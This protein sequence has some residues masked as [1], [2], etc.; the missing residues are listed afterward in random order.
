MSC[1]VL[2][3]RPFAACSIEAGYA[4][5]VYASGRTHHPSA[6]QRTDAGKQYNGGQVKPVTRRAVRYFDKNHIE[7]NRLISVK[8]EPAK[9]LE[10]RHAREWFIDNGKPVIDGQKKSSRFYAI[11]GTA[12][13]RQFKEQAAVHNSVSIVKVRTADPHTQ[14]IFTFFVSRRC[15]EMVNNL[16]AEH[17]DEER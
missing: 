17:L 3:N 1:P 9:L 8:V 14:E 12:V 2:I 13:T 6:L 5:A 7:R 11:S 4:R 16:M 10:Q 15:I